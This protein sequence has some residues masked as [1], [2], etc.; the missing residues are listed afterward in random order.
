MQISVEVLVDAP[1]NQVW[2][3]YTSPDDIVQWNFASDDWHTPRATVD[4]RV[5]GKFVSRM[6]ARDG[7]EGFDFEGTY[8]KI[9][10]HQLIEY[11]FGDRIASITF[12]GEQSGV[13]VTVSFEA[14]DM[15]SVDDQRA[16]WQAI[17]NNFAKH[18]VSKI[19]KQ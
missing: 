5:G 10:E 16:G 9:I 4:L 2:D 14:E 11:S 3:A 15:N 19:S 18:V 6:E 12:S 17:L 1:I 8:T 13:R 7:S